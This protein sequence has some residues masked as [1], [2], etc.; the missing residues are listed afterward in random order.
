MRGVSYGIPHGVPVWY[1]AR[2]IKYET[3]DTQN[4]DSNLRL[5]RDYFNGA[6]VFR[7]ILGHAAARTI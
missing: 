1:N 3:K 6:G 7:A 5:A 4:F 2:W